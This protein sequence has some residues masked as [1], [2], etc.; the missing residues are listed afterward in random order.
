MSDKKSNNSIPTWEDIKKTYTIG[1]GNNITKF[2][3]IERTYTWN[4]PNGK[5]IS[6][7]DIPY[8]NSSL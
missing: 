6:K 3:T 4:L 8:I 1:F 7:C 2:D 5:K